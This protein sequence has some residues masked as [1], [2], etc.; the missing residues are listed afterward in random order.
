MV[1]SNEPVVAIRLTAG[2]D[3]NGN[4]LRLFCVYEDQKG[5]IGTITEGY[6]GSEALYSRYPNAK[7]LHTIPVTRKVYKEFVKE[8]VRYTHHLVS[9]SALHGKASMCITC[10]GEVT[11]ANNEQ[12]CAREFLDYTDATCPICNSKEKYD[13]TL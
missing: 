3:V 11:E 6:E 8:E 5:Y 4:P 12:G 10:K 2:H 1:I 7:L 9:I 13:E